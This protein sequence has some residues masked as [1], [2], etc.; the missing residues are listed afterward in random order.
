MS[1][2]EDDLALFSEDE[3]PRRDTS[4]EALARLKPAFPL[5]TGDRIPM[6]VTTARLTWRNL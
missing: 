2:A 1:P 5:P 3:A 6:P 4:L